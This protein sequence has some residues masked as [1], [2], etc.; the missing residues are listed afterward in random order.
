MQS[1]LILQN[2]IM[3]YRKAVYNDLANYYNVVVLHSGGPSVNKSDRYSEIITPS[4][5]FGKFYFQP[6]SPLSKIADS[7]DAIIVMFDLAWPAYLM[8]LYWKKR[9]KTVQT[10]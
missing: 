4:R 10:P 8:P 3:E 1:I 6:R 5:R 2:E 7:F 9:L